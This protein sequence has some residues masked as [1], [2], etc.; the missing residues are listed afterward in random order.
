MVL[1]PSTPVEKPSLFLILHRSVL[2][3]CSLFMSKVEWSR[4]SQV[5]HRICLPEF[6]PLCKLWIDILQ[7]KVSHL[8]VH[9]KV[10]LDADSDNTTNKNMGIAAEAVKLAKA[11]VTYQSFDFLTI[12]NLFQDSTDVDDAVPLR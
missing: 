3:S 8:H 9:Q 5:T 11:R 1:L 2:K 12:L 4:N 7:M 6:L 10:K